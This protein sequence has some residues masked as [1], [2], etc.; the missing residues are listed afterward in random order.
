MQT[1]QNRLV[2]GA[3]I[4]AATLGSA[5]C[6]DVPR[7]SEATHPAPVAAADAQLAESVQAALEANPYLYA[8]H[9]SVSVEHGN[10]VLR[11]FVSDD[12]D[13][14]RAKKTAAKAAGGRRVVDNLSIKPTQPDNSD[15]RPG[16]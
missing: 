8:A 9:V 14:L 11:G 16:R 15:V 10:I 13:L 12:W 3:L 4:L 5:G 6:A 1:P 7:Q 2:V